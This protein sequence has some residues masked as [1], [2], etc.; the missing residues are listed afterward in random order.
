M[1]ASLA[2][3]TPARAEEGNKQRSLLAAASGECHIV[4][5]QPLFSAATV[6]KTYTRTRVA[7]LPLTWKETFHTTRPE[8]EVTIFHRGCEDISSTVRLEFTGPPLT[9][10]ERLQKAIDLLKSLDPKPESGPIPFNQKRILAWLGSEEARNARRIDH[11]VC[12]HEVSDEC[13]EDAYFT[14]PS[15]NVLVISSIDRP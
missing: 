15:A 4:D 12:F 5:T 1:L 6:G 14:S 8:A 9:K 10:E 7:N 11:T 3:G 2:A 13:I